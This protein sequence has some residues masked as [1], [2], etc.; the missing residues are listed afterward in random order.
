MNFRPILLAAFIRDLKLRHC[1]GWA[2]H[3]NHDQWSPDA[4][5]ALKLIDRSSSVGQ[6]P[7]LFKAKNLLAGWNVRL[8]QGIHHPLAEHP[9]APIAQGHEAVAKL[10]F[11]SSRGP[12]GWIG[13][14]AGVAVAEI[15]MA[16]IRGAFGE[17]SNHRAVDMTVNH[18]HY[19]I[20]NAI[21]I[22]SIFP[23]HDHL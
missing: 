22:A 15:A 20:F 14:L 4:A 7:Q 17:D 9:G 12:S 3:L 10:A 16:S 13:V 11:A 19:I 2:L 1:G 23:T 21:T 6:G 18:C 5:M 8:G